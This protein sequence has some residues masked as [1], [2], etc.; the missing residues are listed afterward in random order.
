MATKRKR[1]LT[2]RDFPDGMYEVIEQ[3]HTGQYYW[4]AVEK[5]VECCFPVHLDFVKAKFKE[6]GREWDPTK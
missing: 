3:D 4:R 1:I 2:N 5:E 6:M